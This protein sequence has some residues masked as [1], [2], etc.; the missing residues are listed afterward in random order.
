MD[1]DDTPTPDTP[2]EIQARIDFVRS[3]V[4]ERHGHPR[5]RFVII[6][7]LLAVVGCGVYWQ[8]F[9]AKSMSTPAASS[10]AATHTAASSENNA[11]SSVPTKTF[12]SA[13]FNLSFNYPE[14]WNVVDSGNGPMT[15]TSPSQQLT[16]ATGQ[17]VAG[18]ITMTIQKQGQLPAGFSAGADLAVLN[19]RMI[20]Y[21]H[22]TASQ[23]SQAYVSFVQ[24]A[25]TST[26]GGLD[27]IYL[28]GNDGYQKDQVI[29][30]GD[31]TGVDPLITVSFTQCGN[32]TC[33]SNLTPLTI[34]SAVWSKA[35]FQAP[36][37]N[38]LISLTFE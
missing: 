32:T 29:P 21:S 14:D 8:F 30:A 9:R 2:A 38:M 28:T 11:A 6:V 34:A 25:S 26:K 13:D 7:A 23:T 36:I 19:S 37:I 27:G 18:E 17:T 35:T 15:V 1:T 31:I 16:N 22:P 5:R 12:T 3:I 10:Q 20:N 24:Y 4:P 33:S